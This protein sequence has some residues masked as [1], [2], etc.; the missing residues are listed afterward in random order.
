MR[1]LLLRMTFEL[2]LQCWQEEKTVP[3]HLN[4]MRLDRGRKNPT[5][6]GADHWGRIVESC[7]KMIDLICKN[8]RQTHMSI[9]HHLHIKNVPPTVPFKGKLCTIDKIKPDRNQL[10]SDHNV[11]FLFFKTVS[12]F[13]DH[14]IWTSNH[15]HDNPVYIQ[16]SWGGRL[17]SQCSF[18]IHT[19]NVTESRMLNY[20]TFLFS[21]TVKCAPSLGGRHCQ[22]YITTPESL[23]GFLS[24]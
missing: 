16:Y 17:L 14:G 24:Q 21:Y 4:C 5:R 10:Q 15:Q 9:V 11:S 12:V 8:T 18:D 1:S 22:E 20:G 6:Q 7:K 3:V 23:S 2:Y 19:G 13:L